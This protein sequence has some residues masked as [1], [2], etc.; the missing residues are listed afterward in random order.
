MPTEE[1]RGSG[2]GS[3][4]QWYGIADSDPYQSVKDPQHWLKV[5]KCKIFDLF[6]FNDFYVIKSL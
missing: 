5:P 2:T 3:G 1:K 4:S 6:D